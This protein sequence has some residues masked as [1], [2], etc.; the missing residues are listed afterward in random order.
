ME[1][2][3]TILGFMLK[4]FINSVSRSL[5]FFSF[6][7]VYVSDANAQTQKRDITPTSPEAAALTKMV[8]YP[9]NLNTGVPNISVPLYQVESGSLKLP[10]SISYHSGGFKI[11]EQSTSVGLGWS[12]SCDIQITR[13]VNGLD[14]FTPA[15]GYIGNTKART[16]YED[17]SC[18]SCNYPFSTNNSA[19]L[20]ASGSEDGLP[21]KFNYRLLNKSG[22]FYFMKGNDGT[23]SFIVPVPFE[24]IQIEYTGN[25]FKIID[26]DGTT[27]IFGAAE[28]LKFKSN[29]GLIN[30]RNSAW[31]C[32]RIISNTKTDTI[33]F[34]YGPKPTIK[35]M[36]NNE[37][38]EYYNNESPCDGVNGGSNLNHQPSNPSLGTYETID[39]KQLMTRY[40]FTS[41]SSPK[42]FVRTNERSVFHLPWV[43]GNGTT[44]SPY[45]VVDR[46]FDHETFNGNNY[47]E[48][49]GY[50]TETLGFFLGR[51]KFRGG[52]IT[53]NGTDQLTSFMVKN[54]QNEEVKTVELVYS[55]TAANDMTNA[56]KRN[57]D[58]FKG[59]L[60]LDEIRF[61]KDGRVFEKYGFLY[62]QKTCFGNHLK[63]SN[64][65]G[66]YNASTHEDSFDDSPAIPMTSIT[67]KFYLSSANGCNSFIPSVTFNVGNANNT[68]LPDEYYMRKGIL[69]RVI[70][71]TG[72]YS[73]FDFEP[74]LYKERGTVNSVPGTVVQMGG[75]LRIRSISNYNGKAERLV[76]QKYYRYGETEDGIGLI[77]N[78]P[79]RKFTYGSVNYDG[80]SYK[81]N[82]YYIK[83]PNS[84]PCNTG[85]CMT[86]YAR[87][88]KTTFLNSA[89]L[90]YAYGSG[91]PIYYTKVTEYNSDMGP[92]TG[93]RVH[94]FY[95]PDAYE[96]PRGTTYSV[97]NGSTIPF[98]Y[99]DG[100][101]GVQKSIEDYK[102]NNGIFKLIHS[103]EFTYQKYKKAEQIRAAY[104]YFL[105]IYNVNYLNVDSGFD[106][107]VATSFGGSMQPGSNFATG[108]Y[109]IA[110]G[111]LLLSSE[112]EKWMDNDGTR[113][114]ST[115]YAYHNLPYLQPDQ[116]ITL[117]TEGERIT[118]NVKY[119]YNYPGVSIY[120]QMK[121]A[122]VNMVSQPI[123][124]I[125]TNTVL[126]KEIGRTV[127]NYGL[128]NEGN[129]FIAPISVQKSS[130]G[131]ALETEVT[132]DKYDTNGNI[133]QLTPK[134]GL[135]KSYLWGYNYKYPI[136]EFDGVDY[137]TAT[138]GVNVATLQT[139]IDEA[140]L[141][142]TL[143]A[144]RTAN[145][146]AMMSSFI[147][148][149]LIGLSSQ[150]GANGISKSFIYDD[151]GRLDMIKDQNDNV[152][153]KYE[154][155]SVGFDVNSSSNSMKYANVPTFSSGFYNCSSPTPLVC[156][157]RNIF[158]AGMHTSSSRDNAIAASKN[159]MGDWTPE[160]I[161]DTE[162]LPP[163]QV[164]S[165]RLF[166]NRLD[167]TPFPDDAHL[168]LFQEGSIVASEKFP[169]VMTTNYQ[170]Y[171]RPGQ[172]KVSI[173]QGP[174]SGGVIIK[175]L[176]S[177]SNGGGFTLATGDTLTLEAGITYNMTITN[178][179]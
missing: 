154:Y 62:N 157:F 136:A 137:L 104:A 29:N 82:V 70:Y 145:P 98:I 173:R 53:F 124:E 68:E 164:A 110:S 24:N 149:P 120:D 48:A 61:K 35:N 129:G 106:P 147:Y 107:Y 95:A 92:L 135:V 91:A 26:D 105:N 116:I 131:A 143:S 39:F 122:S 171:L 155:N 78:M 158:P 103:R 79:P 51:I 2:W 85:L 74:N 93:K 114:Q 123:E 132:F 144:L 20:L 43:Q 37:S 11:G 10:I 156:L 36:P 64:A 59:T 47:T 175:Y 176:V 174:I 72:G 23:T 3:A 15:S 165:I 66:Y 133:L 19:Y 50:Y 16:F 178:A 27:Y 125:V 28:A 76:S 32:D 163:S 161:I 119:A 146:T 49:L 166:A 21:D 113:S 30:Y 40:P 159:Y 167:P 22:S 97:V 12:L 148:K 8:D 14:D 108:Q 109:G 90:D 63:G 18:P 17:S 111:K 31:K 179:L 73:D 150:T 45:Q 141:K 100:L 169:L 56:I 128:I 99:T 126:G 134:T 130:H 172:Y 115:Q 177:T 96:L 168:D 151:Y 38:I 127:T 118:K 58:S 9:I 54:A 84:A 162:C 81:Q 65:W 77:M 102:Y 13:T 1:I 71:P 42:Y 41:L 60:Y 160:A 57:G 140:Q 5:L 80:Y 33:S 121:S 88:T 34:F 112:V 138:S 153:K 139:Q 87:E 46:T 55:Y 75:G 170:R 117:N 152:I 67:Q 69:Q 142:T 83:N 86:A 44:A 101:M 94:T 52:S 7:A 25:G 4:I 6:L 89:V